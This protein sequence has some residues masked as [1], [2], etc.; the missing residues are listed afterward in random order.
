MKIIKL[1]VY[2]LSPSFTSCTAKLH[3][4]I[5]S[6]CKAL[7]AHYTGD[8]TYLFLKLKTMLFMSHD[9]RKLLKLFEDKGLS[10]S[11][12]KNVT[13][14]EKEILV[15][16]LSFSEMDALLYETVTDVLM[17]LTN[18][19]LPIFVKLCDFTLQ[20][21]NAKAVDADAHERNSLE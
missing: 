7:P 11:C 13:V 12:G 10:R 2:G 19:L 18:Y 16:G 6:K 3:E 20:Q 17:G 5:N 15:V 21:A 8:I 4:R 9:M 1:V 14:A